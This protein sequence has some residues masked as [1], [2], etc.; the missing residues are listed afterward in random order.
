VAYFDTL[1]RPMLTVADNGKD[2]NGAVQ[3]MPLV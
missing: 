1:G 2:V 3:N